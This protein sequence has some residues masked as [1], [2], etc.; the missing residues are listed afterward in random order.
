MSRYNKMKKGRDKWKK[1]AVEAKT[2]VRY[3]KK[4]N[5]RIKKERDQ[6]KKA[7][8]ENKKELEELKRR[9]ETLSVCDKTTVVF[10]ALQL[11]GV[12][13]I[14]FRAISRVLA[15]MASQLGLAN[16]PCP[17]TIIN[18]VTR[19]AIVRMKDDTPRVD[20]RTGIPLFSGGFILLLDATIGLGQGIAV[21]ESED[22]GFG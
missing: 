18:W 10:L 11:F 15:V 8:R 2:D 9:N 19:L 4:E 7:W 17:Q 20:L 22:A 1:A 5:K 12:A 13:R 14:G 6:Y 3:S 16:A 21:F